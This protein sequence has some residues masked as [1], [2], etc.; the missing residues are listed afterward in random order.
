M[1]SESPT[2]L[3]AEEMLH[4]MLAHATGG[5]APDAAYKRCRKVLLDDPSISDKLPRFV[6]TCRDPAA[7][8]GYIKAQASGTASYD[9]RRQILREAFEPLMSHLERAHGSPI[10]A[11]VEGATIALNAESVVA[12]WTKAMSR[13]TSDPDGAITAARSLLESVAR[14]SWKTEASLTTIARTT[15]RSCTAA[16]RRLSSSHP[17]ITRRSSFK[18]ILGGCT[19]VVNGLGSI[20]NRA[21]DAHGQGRKSY[22]PAERHAALAVNLAGSMALFLMETHKAR[23]PLS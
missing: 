10:D 17:A 2:F 9:A 4:L 21:S 20:R 12:A 16:Y 3:A 13:R 8:W 22:R 5:E 14:R 7:F 19:T 6:R 1:A 23:A 15:Y 11:E 18:A